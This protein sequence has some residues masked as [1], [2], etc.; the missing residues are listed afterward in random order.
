MTVTFHNRTSGYSKE[1]TP[2]EYAALRLDQ[3]S[4]LASHGAQAGDVVEVHYVGVPVEV[5]D[6]SS[7]RDDWGVGSARPVLDRAQVAQAIRYERGDGPLAPLS[8]IPADDF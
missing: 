8:R 2:E 4:A 7:D 3:R 5:A 6:S 1:L